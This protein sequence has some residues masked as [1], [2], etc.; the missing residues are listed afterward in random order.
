MCIRQRYAPLSATTPASSGSP[1]RRH[2]VDE[3]GAELE[4][5]AGDLGLRR[6]DRDRDA[7]E[8]LEHRDDA[9]Q[10]LVDR[11]A[12]GAGPRRLAA[13]VHDR[14]AVVHHPAR[15]GRRNA[16]IEVHAAVGEAV[17]RHVDDPHHRRA[18][19]TFLDRCASHPA[20]RLARALQ[21]FPDGA[22]RARRAGRRRHR[23]TR[24]DP[25]G[26]GRRTRA[27]RRAARHPLHPVAAPD[28]ERRGAARVPPRPPP[29][30]RGAG[31][32]DGPAA[33]AAGDVAHRGLLVVGVGSLGWHEGSGHNPIKPPEVPVQ[34]SR[35]ASL[36]PTTLPRTPNDPAR[37]RT[38]P[39][40]RPLSRSR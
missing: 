17:G 31:R 28:R 14:R 9:A 11:D 3:L 33:R 39:G 6:V 8:P 18:L 4:R 34:R 32:G 29:Q 10:L 25:R 27:D 37:P 21:R 13:D 23:G 19:Q 22:R 7:V 5:A 12:L 2:V 20:W 24:V 35:R 36:R 40:R 16:R 1:Q 38:S 30:A 15:C 26:R